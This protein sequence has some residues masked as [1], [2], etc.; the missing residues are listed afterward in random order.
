MNY[1]KKMNLLPIAFVALALSLTACLEESSSSRP[2]PQAASTLDE[3]QESGNVIE[4]LGNTV[5]LATYVDLDQEVNALVAASQ[6]LKTKR[7]PEALAQ[8]QAAWK[9]AR[10]PWEST[11]SFLV[12]PVDSLGIDP[13]LDTW[14]LAVTDLNNVLNSSIA[15]TPDLIRGQDMNV[16]GF[17]TAEY[18]LFGNGVTSNTKNISAFTEAEYN[19]LIAV[20]EVM[21]E[22]TGKLVH[23]WKVQADPGDMNS[24]PFIDVFT[25]K[26]TKQVTGFTNRGQV[27]QTIIGLGM[28]KI[29]NEVGNGKLATPLGGDIDAADAS[30]VES[31]F[32]WNSLVDFQNNVES[33]IHLYTGEYGAHSGMGLST[34][35]RKFNPELDIKIR[36]ELQNSKQAIA[37]IAGTDSLSF[38][39]AITDIHGRE[40]VQA[41]IT[42]MNTLQVLL[43]D[44]LLVLVK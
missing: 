17:H 10:I 26:S 25:L 5:I 22:Y 21:A 42:Q 12:G 1:F 16:Q 8:A 13:F 24:G 14:P 4:S 7:T 39:Q 35:V 9:A 29:A 37:N 32:S 38:T 2:A 31:Q 6:N 30:Q 27:L 11:E 3:L 28:V 15:I 34:L 36:F 41:A 33:M 43:R 19:Y 18:L 44:Q 40:R 23:A 20:T